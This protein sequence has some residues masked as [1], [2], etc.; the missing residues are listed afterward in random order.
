MADPIRIVQPGPGAKNKQGVPFNADVEHE[1]QGGPSQGVATLQYTS[2]PTGPWVTAH[3]SVGPL[4]APIVPYS[5]QQPTFTVAGVEQNLPLYVRVGIW[6]DGNQLE[7]PPLLAGE[8][9]HWGLLQVGSGDASAHP[10][11]RTEEAG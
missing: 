7:N 3:P 2:D 5:Q 8:V 11:P 6:A 10:H 4:T 1:V 9:S